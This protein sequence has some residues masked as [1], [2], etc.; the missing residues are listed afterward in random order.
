MQ[1][2]ITRNFKKSELACP[3]CTKC[4]MN[5]VFMDRL[6]VLRDIYGAPLTIVSGYRCPRHNKDVGGAF[7]S[8]HLRGEAVDLRVSDKTSNELYRLRELAFR[9]GFNGIGLGKSQL[10]IGLRPGEPKSWHY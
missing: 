9:L 5:P 1:E 3:C 8:D 10:H 4:E 2:V 6:Q 7:N